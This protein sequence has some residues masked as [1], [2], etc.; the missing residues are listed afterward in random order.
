MRTV[1][2]RVLGSRLTEYIR[3]A[4]A[5]ETILVTDRDR[6]VAEIRPPKES[7]SPVL[8]NAL[9]AEAVRE[10]WL[11]P[12]SPRLEGPPPRP[13]PVLPLQD[14]VADLDGDRSDR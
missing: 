6:V 13:K 14:L 10:G 2:I 11:T 5:G 9:L 3:M 12:P 1:E 7:M 4:S 8:G